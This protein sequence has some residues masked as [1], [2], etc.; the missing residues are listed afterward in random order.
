[1]MEECLTN[2]FI[3]SQRQRDGELR[4][5]WF[6]RSSPTDWDEV[7]RRLKA[8]G[9]NAIFVRVGR[10]GN[11]IYKSEY[12][13][14]D[15]WVRK[16]KHDEVQR[17]IETAHRYG[18]QFHAWRVCFHM[19]SAPEWY[20]RRLRRQG[21][22]VQGYNGR[23]GRW[24]NPNDPRN[25]ELEVNVIREL[26]EKYDVDGVHLDYIRFPEVP[27]YHYDYSERSRKW[28]EAATG[29]HLMKFPDD[30]LW[31]FY[32]LAYDDWQ[33]NNVTELVRRIY[34]S[35]KEIKPWVKVSAAV[36]PNP[37]YHYA[38][39]KQDWLRWAR[40]GILDFVVPMNYTASNE[41]LMRYT[42]EQICAVGGSIPIAIGLGVW[43]LD[44][45][46]QLVQQVATVREL[47]ADGFVLFSYNVAT[48]EEFL[49][50][51]S[52]SATAKATYPGY[53]SPNVKFAVRDAVARRDAP[54]AAV[55]GQRVVLNVTVNAQHAYRV[56]VVQWQAALQLV[57]KN[58]TLI[59]QLGTLSHAQPQWHGTF[60]VRNG[61]QRPVVQGT[62][63]LADGN[64]R[65]F[66]R[67][68]PWIEGMR[69]EAFNEM[70]ATQRPP[71]FD[72]THSLTRVGIYADGAMAHCI[73]EALKRNAGNIQMALVGRIEPSFLHTIDCLI[74]PPFKDMTALT[75]EHASF[76]RHWVKRGKRVIL[77]GHAVGYGI[78]PALFPEVGRG[79]KRVNNAALRT[80]LLYLP[81]DEQMLSE[82]PLLE[83]K[84]GKVSGIIIRAPID[85][86][87]LAR[88]VPDESH[89]KRQGGQP[90]IVGKAFGKGYVVLCGVTY[91]INAWQDSDAPAKL[92]NAL[93]QHAIDEA[94]VKRD[95][96]RR[97][98]TLWHITCAFLQWLQRALPFGKNA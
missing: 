48:L 85:A 22:L 70:I 81:F 67:R 31:T 14:S 90:A 25:R 34:K 24:A 92:L 94:P 95:S 84:R 61:W 65:S 82:H 50:A 71:V 8:H 7:M 20:R 19:G 96:A 76:L 36:W 39:I 46:K 69:E 13:P 4:G 18:I 23:W 98:L 10:G 35:V 86:H 33:R 62:C 12:L 54:Y 51:L 30:A 29:M 57:D 66:V 44:K 11:V 75:F 15:A 16:L 93:I 91:D 6:F 80:S 73:M 77:L 72:A 40:E 1:N 2:A 59:T 27:H 17:A 42:A 53:E 63:K 5:I 79:I 49:S 28:F 97:E 64:I 89:A 78:Y 21:R 55:V 37:R 88:F 43:L 68:G 47:G 56:P 41:R 87:I 52:R 45:P 9:L 3:A 26:V 58:E 60:A 83:H 38:T 74:I 32:R